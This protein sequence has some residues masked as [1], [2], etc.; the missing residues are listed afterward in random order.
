MGV[1]RM[2]IVRHG[3]STWNA[4][5]RWQG[6]A[7]P[8]LSERGELQALEATHALREHGPF[9]IVVTSTLER[10]RRTGELLAERLGVELGG[11]L[12][13]LSERA[14]GEWEGLTRIEIEARYPGYLAADRRPPGY[15]PDAS[16][17]ARSTEALHA[18]CAE[19]PHA[20][21]LVVSHGGIIHALERASAE[22]ERWER[23]D[24]LAGRWFEVHEDAVTA[25]G[26][27]IALVADGGPT[28]PPDRSYA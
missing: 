22:G 23:L 13:G 9:D 17:V 6:Q 26:A 4:E 21:M 11:A 20:T 1:P 2:L 7:D 12:P 14:A 24:N 5:R 8:S 27:R 25:V 19:R 28:P 15:E 3:E 10:A 16:I 18:L